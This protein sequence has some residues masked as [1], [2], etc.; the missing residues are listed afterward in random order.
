MPDAPSSSPDGPRA[1]SASPPKP[2]SLRS[3]AGFRHVLATGRRKRVGDLVVVKA[4]G[5]PG[6]IRYGLVAGRRIGTAVS[7]N[8][9]KRRLRQA[10]LAAGLDP[11]F[12][13]VLI[14][15]DSTP[16]IPFPTLVTWLKQASDPQTNPDAS[17]GG[18]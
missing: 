5:E 18:R 2:V 7:R 11:G 9:A 13:Y 4:E 14:A 10:V 12:D 6:T 1:V 3:P 17:G 16:T 8:R 15:G